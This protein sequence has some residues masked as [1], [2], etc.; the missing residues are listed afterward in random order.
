MTKSS[1]TYVQQMAEN[2]AKVLRR[3]YGDGALARAKTIAAREH[4]PTKHVLLGIEILQ[5]SLDV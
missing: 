2:F 4:G 1:E 3:L 5:D